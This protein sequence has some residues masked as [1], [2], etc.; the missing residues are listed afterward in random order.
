MQ[1]RSIVAP[2]EPQ[3][4]SSTSSNPQVTLSRPLLSVVIPILNEEDS[5]QT[6]YTRLTTELERL[7]QPY[8]IIA[9]DDGSTDMSFAR[10]RALAREDPRLRIVRF[11]RNF[12]Q[13]AAF[14]AG[15]DRAHGDVVI[16][17]DA[18][19]QNDPA[20][21]PNLLAKLSEGYDV[22]SGWRARRQDPFLRRRLP[23]LIANRLISIVTGT[24][25]HDYGC[26]LKAYR[27]EVVQDIQLYGELHRFIP[28]IASWQGIS[29]TEI[30][31]NHAPRRYG[32]SKYSLGRTSRVVLDLLTVRFLLSYATRP[33]QIFGLWGL[34]IGS[35]ATVILGWLAFVRLI[36]LH[37]IADRP[38]LLLG[39][40]LAVIA[41][42][43]VGIG[44]IGE[45][46]IR[47]AHT[48]Q[49]PGYRVREEVNGDLMPDE[50]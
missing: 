30:P 50:R 13:T 22:V 19:L 16:T 28:A 31:V 21:I 5:I 49:R 34:I 7:E 41:M 45:M 43:F 1:V 33:M 20:D 23:S 48:G 11:R 32:K 4:T 47:A 27:R 15:F 40:L 42:Q 35:V 9:I 26:S 25:L 8:E 46:I 24:N 36:L 17:I 38:L 10:L 3:L 44:L 2:D 29:I 14:T 18:D 37:P 12:G 39:I 6:L